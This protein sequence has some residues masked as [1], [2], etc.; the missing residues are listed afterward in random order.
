[1]GGDRSLGV[2]GVADAFRLESTPSGCGESARQNEAL[3]TKR[4]NVVDKVIKQWRWGVGWGAGGVGS[5]M[6]RAGLWRR[7]RGGLRKW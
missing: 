2:L 6:G 5:S 7:C 1:M 3:G 4:V